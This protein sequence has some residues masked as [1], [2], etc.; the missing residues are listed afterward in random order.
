MQIKTIVL[1]LTGI[2]SHLSEWLSLVN[3][4]TASA[5]E[6]VEKGEPFCTVGGNADWCSHCGKQNGI[7]SKI[8]NGT[9]SDPVIPLLGIYPKKPKTPIQKNLCAPMF[10]AALFAIANIWKQP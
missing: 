4:Q 5:G 8:K 3:Q 6:D 2:I 1:I 9:A 7:S 10:I